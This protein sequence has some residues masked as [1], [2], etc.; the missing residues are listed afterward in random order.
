MLV[1]DEHAGESGR[2]RFAVEDSDDALAGG[3]VQHLDHAGALA[4]VFAGGFY[5]VPA[6]GRVL[7]IA[8]ED[9]GVHSLGESDG[10]DKSDAS[11]RSDF[12]EST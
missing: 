12:A 3:G 1:V 4:G 10:S 2:G 7:E 5:L 8:V 11:D 6:V 9:G